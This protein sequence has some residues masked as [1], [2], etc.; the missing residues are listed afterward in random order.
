MKIL[1][2][3]PKPQNLFAKLKTVRFEPLELEYLAAVANELNFN[4]RIYD[5]LLE[6]QPFS[7]FLKDNQPDVVAITGYTIHVN[8]IKEYAEI[9]KEYGTNIKVVVGGIHAELNWRDFYD[10][11]IDIIIHANPL[12]AFRDV[13]LNLQNQGCWQPVKNI[14]FKKD[15]EWI[16]NQGESL[17]PN[18]LP[19]PDRT[20]LHLYKDKFRYFGKEQCALVKT[21]W[22]CPYSCNFCYCA[23]LNGGEYSTR[24]ITKVVRE[25]SDL[26]QEKIFIIDDDFLVDKNR[27]LEFCRLISVY[28]IKKDFSIYGRADLICAHQDILSKLKASGISEIIVGL[29]AVDDETLNN[30]NKK[31]STHSNLQAIELLRKNGIKSCGLFIVNEDYGL[32]DFKR[33]SAIVKKM[34]L[35]LCMF[36]IFTPLKGVPGYEKYQ[37]RLIIPENKYENNDFLHLNIKPTKLSVTRFYLEFYKLYLLAYSDVRRLRSNIRP[38][39]KSI[40]NLII[41]GIR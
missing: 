13:L 35:D 18:T 21:A 34:A 7:S 28:N 12:Q 23:C 31:T 1:L 5:G 4:Y 40:L 6:R 27:L 29:E 33:L 30:Y 32:E 41:G 3:R 16:K 11:N 24:D 2:V 38:I 25:I 26:E 17:V 9:V 20:H 39:I 19:L 22:G 14:C 36:S 8:L 15:N 10:F 37:E